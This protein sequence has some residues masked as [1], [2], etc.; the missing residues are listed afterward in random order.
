M[1]SHGDLLY[2]D[3]T[4]QIFDKGNFFSNMKFLL[5]K[6]PGG[7]YEMISPRKNKLKSDLAI[8]PKYMGRTKKIL[9]N[10]FKLQP[11]PT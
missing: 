7:K 6:A 8:S 2:V 3:Q 10:F 4:A 5:L 1:N 9:A 11:F